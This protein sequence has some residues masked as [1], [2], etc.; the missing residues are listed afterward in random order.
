MLEGSPLDPLPHE[1]TV[2]SSNLGLISEIPD[3]AVKLRFL[4]N[5]TPV[6]FHYISTDNSGFYEVPDSVIY[7]PDVQKFTNRGVLCYEY[8]QNRSLRFYQGLRVRSTW[9]LPIS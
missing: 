1:M 8:L 4:M 7:W 2:K 6:L 5:L 3:F 9:F